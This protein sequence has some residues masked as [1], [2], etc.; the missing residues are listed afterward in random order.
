MVVKLYRK[1]ERVGWLGWIEN[2]RGTCIG[3]IALDG[4]VTFDW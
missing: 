3:F 4:K 1:P 2:S